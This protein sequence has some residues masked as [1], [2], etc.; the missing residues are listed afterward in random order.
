MMHALVLR[1]FSAVLRLVPPLLTS[2]S[3]PSTIRAMVSS[4][5]LEASSEGDREGH[6][7]AI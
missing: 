5:V 1:P 2:A 6:D 4:W 7:G 3:R